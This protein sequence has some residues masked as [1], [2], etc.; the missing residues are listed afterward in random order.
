MDNYQYPSITLSRRHT[1]DKNL[2]ELY[3]GEANKL[4]YQLKN[5]MKFRQLGQLKMTRLFTD[6]TIITAWS[7]FG[8]D[9]VNVDV[10]RTTPVSIAEPV[11]PEIPGQCTITFINLS[12]YVQP[13]RYPGVIMA[14]EVEGIDYHKTYYTIDAS[15]CPTCKDIAWE[16][17]FRYLQSSPLVPLSE[18][19]LPISTRIEWPIEPLHRHDY[20]ANGLLLDHD[21]TDHTVYSPEPS[22][23]GEI[24]KRGTDAGGTYIIWK[25]YTEARGGIISRTGLGIMRLVAR[26]KD[27]QDLEKCAQNARIEVDC[28][29]KSDED[30]PVVIHWEKCIISD[31]CAAPSSTPMSVL[32]YFQHWSWIEMYLKANGDGCIPYEWSLSGMGEIVP[33]WGNRKFVTYKVPAGEFYARGCRT[34]LVIT[35]DDRC[36][37]SDSIFFKSC[38]DSS[39]VPLLIGY[40]SLIMGCGESQTLTASGGC[41]PYSWAVT[42]GVGSITQDGVYTAPTTNPN[43]QNPTITVTECCGNSAD[44]KLAVNCNPPDY[45]LCASTL[46]FSGATCVGTDCNADGSASKI[47]Y[48]CDGS[49]GVEEYG[50]QYGWWCYCDKGANCEPCTPDTILAVAQEYT[51]LMGVGGCP[52]PPPYW[53]VVKDLR[54]QDMK[55]AG[56]CPLNPFT[57]LPYD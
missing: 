44:V 11:V 7:I 41:G 6:G 25:A 39:P 3:R 28:C 20:D 48:F 1:G 16:F 8:Q 47:V 13:M 49:I 27:G 36:G 15:N 54:T 57:G 29:I 40:T 45:A 14:G 17:L 38:C 24:I 35:S 52:A 56:C 50:S 37:T 12:S 51:V 33:T 21:G 31:W 22:A 26:I 34:Q 53:N 46:S 4:L 2:A 23:W 30:R 19:P 43:C 9:F 42:G 5:L 55:D 18:P 10:S 32:A